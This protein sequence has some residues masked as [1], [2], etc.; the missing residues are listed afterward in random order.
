MM[1]VAGHKKTR[2]LELDGYDHGMVYPALPLVMKE[3]ENIIREE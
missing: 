3:I 1:K 2:L